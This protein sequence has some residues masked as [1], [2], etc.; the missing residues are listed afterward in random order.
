MA[1]KTT[2]HDAFGNLVS[3]SEGATTK[4]ATAYGYDALGRMVHVTDADGVATDMTYSILG[5]RTAVVRGKLDLP[6]YDL[7]GNLIATHHPKP[8]GFTGSDAAWIST[9]SYDAADRVT[10]SL[11]ATRGLTGA[12]VARYMVGAT[13]YTYDEASHRNGVGRLTTVTYPF[14]TQAYEYAIDG[15]PLTER[16]TFS[17]SPDG[18]ALAASGLQETL[19]TPLGSLDQ[20]ELPD[21]PT[22]PTSMRIVVDLQ[23]RP[24]RIDLGN[25]M[26]YTRLGVATFTR[27]GAGLVATRS[28][29]GNPNVEQAFTVRPDGTGGR[30]TTG[31]SWGSRPQGAPQ[32]RSPARGSP[33][34]PTRNFD[35]Q[36]AGCTPRTGRS[37]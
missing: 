15:T 36:R 16:R 34:T 6:D 30:S 26:S 17:V 2:T 5:P 35:P 19:Y 33:T 8:S 4:A 1:H 27:N 24:S 32:R 22:T 23:G 3:V 13:K 28:S 12:L 31:S 11:P 25:N 29:L 10:V 7:D 37:R 21:D 18:A 14:G 9:W 20:I